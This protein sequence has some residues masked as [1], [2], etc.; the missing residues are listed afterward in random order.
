MTYGLQQLQFRGR[1]Q[2]A[3]GSNKKLSGLENHARMSE[4]LQKNS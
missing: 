1:A 2:R 3:L 4:C